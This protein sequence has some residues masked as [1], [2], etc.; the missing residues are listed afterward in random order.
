MN[1]ANRCQVNVRIQREQLYLS[2]YNQLISISSLIKVFELNN[3][4]NLIEIKWL[5]QL[6]NSLVSSYFEYKSNKERQVWMKE[7]CFKMLLNL[8]NLK[9]FKP[10]DLETKHCSSGSVCDFIFLLNLIE[11]LQIKAIGYLDLPEENSKCL[12]IQNK[13][14]LPKR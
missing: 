10:T 4:F 13:E 8:K 6:N 9:Q 1:K 12:A 11:T 5:N 14:K 2:S 7:F 3:K